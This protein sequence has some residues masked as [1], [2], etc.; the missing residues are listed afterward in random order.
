MARRRPCRDIQTPIRYAREAMKCAPAHI[1]G[2]LLLSNSRASFDIRNGLQADSEP[3]ACAVWFVVASAAQ[4]PAAGRAS[5]PGSARPIP[6]RGRLRCTQGEQLQG[7]R[8]AEGIIATNTAAELLTVNSLD[9]ATTPLPAKLPLFAW[10]IGGAPI[11]WYA[12]PAEIL[13]N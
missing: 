5:R 13:I 12:P 2:D 6:F 3:P 7:L 4:E 9:V 11:L 10:K 1:I 8:I